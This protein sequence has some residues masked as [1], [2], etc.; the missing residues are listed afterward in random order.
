MCLELNSGFILDRKDTPV[1]G[2][3]LY[4]SRNPI[5]TKIEKRLTKINRSLA[6][7]SAYTCRTLYRG[8]NLQLFYCGFQGHTLKV[9]ESDR[10]KI[11]ING[12]VYDRSDD[13]FKRDL[14][15]LA[16]KAFGEN[17]KIAAFGRELDSRLSMVDGEYN[18][19]AVEKASD[20]FLL[21]ND[22]FGKLLLY[23]YR[24]DDRLVISHEVKFMQRVLGTTDIDKYA[25]AEILQLKHTIG[26]KSLLRDIL[27]LP[28][29]AYVHSINGFDK[30]E[31]NSY[32]EWVLSEDDFGKPASVH[33]KNLVEMFLEATR[34]RERCGLGNQ[35]LI[36]LSGGLDSRAVLCGL[37][38]TDSEVIAASSIDFGLA[39]Q[40][41]VEVGGMIAE[42]YGTRWLKI[43]L[44]Q[45]QIDDY[46]K[47][48]EMRDGLNPADMAP[49]L[50]LYRYLLKEFDY[51]IN[52]YTGDGGAHIK[53]PY[54]MLGRLKSA[55]N[56][57]HHV[58]I[59]PARFSREDLEGLLR[60]K[61]EDYRDY[62]I[63]IIESYPG[64]DLYDKYYYYI[65]FDRRISLFYEG[66]E[67]TRAF[68]WTCTPFEAQPFYSL[69]L[70]I[71]D[72]EKSDFKL[73]RQFL[74][75]LD[76]RLLE[77][78]YAD[79][80]CP[81]TSKTALW[82]MKTKALLQEHTRL[83]NLARRVL[84]PKIY[85]PRSLPE[86]HSEF[87]KIINSSELISEVFDKD[88]LLKIINGQIAQT[89]YNSLLTAIIY[90]HQLEKSSRMVW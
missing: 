46:L 90:C 70:Q 53:T 57:F 24:N 12:R 55:D 6:R 76:P 34:L 39:N 14:D 23:Y 75:D 67:R 21:F 72:R 41:D 25:I 36:G 77:I 8:K 50:G 42:L 2:L 32:K 85:G 27:R 69:A 35:A 47:I 43:Y 54:R 22:S 37:E 28:H 45:I 68:F 61:W 49:A 7:F 51:G 58:L 59:R 33:S 80:K 48:I 13:Q 89:N 87:I 73:F 31:V 74:H 56:I 15:Y 20:R 60:I 19:V 71:P 62:T 78:Q 82:K 1:P 10:F 17:M 86:S 40:H 5:E 44:E 29:A 83:L 64:R 38:N 63:S 11:F 88:Y 4:Y 18:V 65:V 79:L 81:I 16:D 66:E 30:Y 26:N 9:Y 3:S 52:F 84:Y